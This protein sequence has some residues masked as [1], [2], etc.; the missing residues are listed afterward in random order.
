MKWFACFLL[1]LISPNFAFTCDFT[2][3]LKQARQSG[4]EKMDAFISTWIE[5]LEY[6]PAFE[7]GTL[8]VTAN[9]GRDEYIFQ[10]FDQAAWKRFKLAES[11]GKFFNQHIRGV[12]EYKVPCEK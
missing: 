1:F 9:R 11:K 12:E 5:E 8:I 2:Q 4:C 10:R 6:C 7:A 3:R